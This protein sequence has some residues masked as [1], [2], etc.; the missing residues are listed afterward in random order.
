MDLEVLQEIVNDGIYT[1]DDI[2]LTPRQIMD[3]TLLP[4]EEP[5]RNPRQEVFPCQKIIKV[6]YY[7]LQ[8]CMKYF[9]GPT[10][11]VMIT[12]RYEDSDGFATVRFSTDYSDIWDHQ[13]WPV[14][15]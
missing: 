10:A 7:E 5:S 14:E 2:D 1:S 8:I 12:N 13:F 3:C 6:P 4:D 9:C 11:A 15:Q